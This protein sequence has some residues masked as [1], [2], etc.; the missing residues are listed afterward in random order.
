MGCRCPRC[1]GKNTLNQGFGYSEYKSLSIYCNDCHD[2]VDTGV[3]SFN[4]MPWFFN[5]KRGIKMNYGIGDVVVRKGVKYE[6]YIFLGTTKDES[7]RIVE[8]VRKVVGDNIEIGMYITKPVRVK[9][10]SDGEYV[11]EI[12]FSDIELFEK[13]K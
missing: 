4:H 11:T 7:I 10:D 1:H 6:K 2:F 8:Q 12:V 9:T 3:F 13:E 5:L